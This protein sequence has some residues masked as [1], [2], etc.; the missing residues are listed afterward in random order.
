M[1]T[2]ARYLILPAILGAALIALPA[3]ADDAA[4]WG[5]GHGG[6]GGGGH[7]GGGGGGNGG[8]NGGGEGG[9]GRVGSL[10]H[11]C[12]EGSYQ[13]W[14][15]NKQFKVRQGGGHYRASRKRVRVHYKQHAVAE[16]YEYAPAQKV[17]V[18]EPHVVYQPK[19]VYEKKVVHRAKVIKTRKTYIR[20]KYHAVP[21]PDHYAGPV[22][23]TEETVHRDYDG[24][25]VLVYK[26]VER[27]ARHKAKRRHKHYGA[28]KRKYSH[29]R[30]HKR[31][32]SHSRKYY[33]ARP[34]VPAYQGEP[35]HSYGTHQPKTVYIIKRRRTGPIHKKIPLFGSKKSYRH[36][37]YRKHR[38]CASPCGY[39]KY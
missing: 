31:R 4:A 17:I 2:R 28:H 39:M 26:P 35:R 27:R 18:Y 32:K 12:A 9:G 38:R 11:D 14:C 7:G 21:R 10:I 20:P 33:A 29:K 6:D 8:G 30:Y 3:A 25:G 34:V 24:H 23:T 22:M 19:V 36:K 13:F 1:F 5:S 15:R 16:H 37:V